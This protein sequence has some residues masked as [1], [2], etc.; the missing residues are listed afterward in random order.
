MDADTERDP[1]SPSIDAYWRRRAVALIGAAA[2]VGVL[3]WGCTGGEDDRREQ[4]GNAAAT[5]TP[6]PVAVPSLM[7]TV[8]VTATRSAIASAAKRAHNGCDP[9]RIVVDLT[10][11][12]DTYAGGERPR[13]QLSVV[14]TGSR[15]CA[16]DIGAK[17][18][19]VRISSG[20]DRVWSSA[21]CARGAGSSRVTLE[22][23]VPHLKSVTWNR[24]RS[25][26]GCPGNAPTARPGTY[27]AAA[28]ET[29]KVFRLR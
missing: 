18:L 12:R 6:S 21:H 24:R 7:P 20:S 17:G 2:V 13:F 15:A 11:D 29:R 9:A 25:T 19:E 1:D 8:T 28:G 22:R 27:V 10:S 5:S 26:A 14:N 16:V 3:A 4:V 23:G